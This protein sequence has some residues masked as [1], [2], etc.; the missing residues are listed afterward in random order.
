VSFGEILWEFFEFFLEF[1][2][3]SLVLELV[4]EIR[5][6]VC[7]GTES[8]NDT[9]SFGMQEYRLRNLRSKSISS[10]REDY[11]RIFSS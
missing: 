10:L 1:L 9:N 7:L 11:F 4:D 8:I 2:F 6:I 3:I 5:R